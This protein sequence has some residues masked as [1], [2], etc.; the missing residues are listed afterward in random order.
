M[1]MK[2]HLFLLACG[3]VILIS[4]AFILLNPSE[5]LSQDAKSTSKD[6]S[7]DKK[8]GCIV[9]ILT[10]QKLFV[11][12][13]SPSNSKKTGLKKNQIVDKTK[14]NAL[15]HAFKAEL[16]DAYMIRCLPGGTL[17]CTPIDWTMCPNE[18]CPT[19]GRK[20]EITP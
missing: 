13:I 15:T 8:E 4:Q 18:G 7:K 14:G 20:G 5:N 2:K 12:E 6:A 9:E 10:G 16:K 19:P 1:K 17:T 3:I 11:T